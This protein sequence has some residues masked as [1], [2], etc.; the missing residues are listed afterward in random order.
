VL[1]EERHRY[2]LEQITADKRVRTEA[3][4]RALAVSVDTVRRDLGELEKS[5]RLVRVHGGAIA[6]DFHTPFQPTE[7]YAQ[8]EKRRIARK[9]LSLIRDGMTVLAGGGTVML[10]MARMF[11][12]TLTG[13]FFTV[14]PLVALEVAQRSSIEVIL[15]S[16]RL[17]RSHYICTGATVLAQV[18]D[19]RADLC[20]MGTNGFAVREGI[21]EADWEVMQVKKAIIRAAEKTAVL[22]IAEKHGIAHRFRVCAIH[23]TDYL[24]TEREPDDPLL[25][26]YNGHCKVL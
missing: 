17:S 4:S 15:I 22:S 25:S 7:V 2:I 23:E 24:I 19:I 5:G 3:L 26:D 12:E 6:V 21:T 9:A 20:L 8:K 11:P 18:G 10:E 13:A 1:Q 14:S 16:G